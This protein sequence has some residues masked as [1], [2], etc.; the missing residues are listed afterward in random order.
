MAKGS[1]NNNFGAM[2]GGFLSESKGT[3][4]VETPDGC[5]TGTMDLG[6][7]ARVSDPPMRT[8]GA[9]SGSGKELVVNSGMGRTKLSGTP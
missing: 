5:Q 7:Y 9:R 3:V 2:P 6:P 4:E 8:Y 1:R